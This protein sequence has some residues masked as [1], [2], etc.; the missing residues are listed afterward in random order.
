M[1]TVQ[2]VRDVELG[3]AVANLLDSPVGV[4]LHARR[5]NHN[6]VVLGH[7]LQ[8]FL[9]ERPDKDVFGPLIEVHQSL[10]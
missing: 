1:L 4:V 5:E 9:C 10:I 7:L 8:E 2:F 3:S 6:L